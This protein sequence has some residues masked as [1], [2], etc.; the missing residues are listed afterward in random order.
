M[1]AYS[2]KRYKSSILDDDDDNNKKRVK[3]MQNLKY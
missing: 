3:I 1:S 2:T